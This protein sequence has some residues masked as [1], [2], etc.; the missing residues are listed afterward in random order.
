MAVAYACQT[1]VD[2]VLPGFPMRWDFTVYENRFEDEDGPKYVGQPPLREQGDVDA[3][4]A[5]IQ[6]GVVH[7]VCTDHAPW[8]LAAKLDPAQP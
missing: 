1:A 5:S 7:T 8:S 2:Q 4:W 6:Q 3:L